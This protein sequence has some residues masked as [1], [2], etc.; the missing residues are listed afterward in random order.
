MTS[1]PGYVID[2]MAT[3]LDIAG[4]EYP[5][6]FQSR[7]PQPPEGKSLTP[8][9]CGQQREGHDILCFSVPRNEAIRKGQGKLVNAERGGKW[10]LYD[11][12]T[13]PTETTNVAAL[14]PEKVAHMVTSFERW[15]SRVG[16]N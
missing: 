1:Q 4:V 8:V 5:S 3:F 7:K 12:E 15:Q 14:Y 13:D 16:D 10:E 2:F 11:M 6:E 9:F